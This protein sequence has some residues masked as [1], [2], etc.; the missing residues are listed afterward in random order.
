MVTN[1]IICLCQGYLT[2][3][4]TPQAI[5]QI[6]HSHPG[7][8]ISFEIKEKSSSIECTQG[9]LSGRS[10]PFP[11]QK[12]LQVNPEGGWRACN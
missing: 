2:L 1:H 7:I 11:A 3:L 8:H 5:A 6:I 9:P 10:F 4:N 12:Q